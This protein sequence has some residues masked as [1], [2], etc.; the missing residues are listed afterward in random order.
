MNSGLSGT[1]AA[2]GEAA[3]NRLTMLEANAF[4]A[5]ARE[6]LASGRAEIDLSNFAPIDSSA[7]AALL[8]LR[9]DST[10]L[11]PVFINPPDNLRKLAVLYGV[12]AMLF[13]V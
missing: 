3:R 5:E 11:K 8:A 4:L 9:R 13:P 6:Q 2:T 7:V 12:E 1:E 10:A